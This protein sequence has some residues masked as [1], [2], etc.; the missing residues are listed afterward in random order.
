MKS[1]VALL[2]CSQYTP[3]ILEE[4]VAEAIELIGGISNFVKPGSRVLLKPN[5]LMAKEPECGITTHPEVV[6]AVARV[7]K[8][9]GCTILLGDGP[10]VW[11]NQIQNVD[12]VYEKT[13]MKKVCDEEGIEL[14][15]F[16][17]RR[18][19]KKFPLTTWLDDCDCLVSVPK[20]K[21]HEFTVLTA[22]VKNLFGL[23]SGTYKTELHKNFP[24]PKEFA[25]ILTD[26]YSEAKPAL[27]V[28]DGILALQGD[29]PATGG[30]LCQKGIIL[31]G[32][33]CIAIDSVLALIMGL[34]PGDIPTNMIGAARGLGNMELSGIQILGENPESLADTDFKLPQTSLKLKLLPHLGALA[35]KLIRFYPQVDHDKC[36][37]CFSCVKAC[38]KKVIC[39]KNGKIKIDYSGCISCFC[40]QEVCPASAITVKKSLLARMLGL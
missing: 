30:E 17:K 15:K 5:L 20:F 24:K 21:T 25:G 13:G 9:N 40:C 3:D 10:S 37:K 27:T 12:E 6:R 19:R 32:S 7:L 22:A 39:L 18:W 1:K 23:V 29:G 8:G 2:R 16:D 28:V 36:I 11:G 14:V 38:P 26:I 33:D 34:S 31:A 4:K 35:A